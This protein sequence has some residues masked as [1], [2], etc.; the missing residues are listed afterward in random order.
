M[1]CLS[2]KR[3]AGH[4]HCWPSIPICRLPIPCHPAPMLRFSVS[5]FHPSPRKSG[6][7]AHP[8]NA[9]PDDIESTSRDHRR[10]APLDPQHPRPHSLQ[11]ASPW[12]P[13]DL[14]A[15]PSLCH[16]DWRWRRLSPRLHATIPIRWPSD[17]FPFGQCV[18]APV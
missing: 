17:P 16:R 2:P 7:H 14:L 4:F 13:S 3:K 12:L 11:T 5:G 18:L 15:E 9:G 6:K 10:P 1:S 8:S